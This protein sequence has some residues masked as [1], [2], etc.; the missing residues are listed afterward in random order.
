[1]HTAIK[2]FLLLISGATQTVEAGSG[3]IIAI[4]LCSACMRTAYHCTETA[5]FSTAAR[6]NPSSFVQRICADQIIV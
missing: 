2:T 6:A 4:P 1:M 3:F 5:I